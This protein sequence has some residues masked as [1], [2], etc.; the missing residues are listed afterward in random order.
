MNFS[1]FQIRFVTLIIARIYFTPCF[2]LNFSVKKIIKN[3]ML[4]EFFNINGLI[5]TFNVNELFWVAY[6]KLKDG[7]VIG[8]KQYSCKNTHLKCAPKIFIVNYSTFYRI[9]DTTDCHCNFFQRTYVCNHT[10]WYCRPFKF[11]SKQF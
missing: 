11:Q 1:P 9:F 8:D 3:I 6:D 7:I 10:F 4:S 2:K 5:V